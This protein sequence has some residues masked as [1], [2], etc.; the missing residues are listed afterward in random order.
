[1]DAVLE[2]MS[3][4]LLAISW[5]L[6]PMTA[7][8]A[9]QVSRLLA[10]VA[11][12]GWTCDVVTSSNSAFPRAETAE[13]ELAELYEPHYTRNVVT[14][15]PDAAVAA[16][17]DQWMTGGFD[18]AA[19]LLEREQ[20][21]ALV[22][23]A[24]P[25][26]DHLI[27][28]RLKQAHPSLPWVAHFSDPWT[29]SPYLGHISEEARRALVEQ[30]SAIVDAAD[31]VVFVTQETADLVMK[32]YETRLRRKVRV[33]PHCLDLDSMPMPRADQQ[34]RV[35]ANVLSLVHAGSLYEGLRPAGALLDAMANVRRRFRDM[36]V[37]LHFLGHNPDD[38]TAEILGRGLQ[39][40]VTVSPPCSWSESLKIASAADVLLVIDRP[41]K[42][43][44][45]L[46]SK[47][48]EY[49]SLDRRIL[50]LT[51][52]KG[53][54]A[55]VMADLGYRT[56]PPDRASKIAEA[57]RELVVMRRKG[58]PLLST[59]HVQVRD[60][61]SAYKVAMAFVGV[62]G[63]AARSASVGRHTSPLDGAEIV[64]D[65]GGAGT[66]A[67]RPSVADAYREF[68]VSLD[69]VGDA[70]EK[71]MLAF[72][73]HTRASQLAHILKHPRVA[74][75]LLSWDEQEI[76]ALYPGRV[77]Q[78][79]FGEALWHLPAV[80]APTLMVFGY[81]ELIGARRLIDCL[82]HGIRKIAIYSPQ[83]LRWQALPI[84]LLL[85]RVAINRLR[86]SGGFRQHQYKSGPALEARI[87]GKIR[88]ALKQIDVNVTAQAPPVQGRI[89]MISASLDAGG[90]ERQVVNTAGSLIRQGYRDVSILCR[91]LGS[92]NPSFFRGAA[93]EQGA[94][95]TEISTFVRA[96]LDRIISSHRERLRR[97]IQ[98]LP[99]E[100]AG[101]VVPL[102]AEL[103]L[104]RPQVMHAW[105]DQVNVIAG[106]AAAIAGVPRII[107]AGRSVAP[108]NFVFY[109]PHMWGAYRALAEFPN[110]VITNNSR[111]GARDYAQWL[112]LPEDRFRVIRNGYDFAE[113]RGRSR[114]EAAAFRQRHGFSS[115][116][117]VIGTIMRFSEEKQPFLW[118]EA[119]AR[120]SREWPGVRFLMIGDGPMHE[121]AGRLAQALGM[122]ARISMPGREKDAMLALSSMDLFLLTSRKE[123]LPNTLIE[124]QAAGVPVVST[125]A[126]GA[127]EAFAQGVTGFLVKE[128]TAE[129]LARQVSEIL[130]DGA[131]RQR[132]AEAAPTFVR[133][134][135]S[136][137]RLVRETLSIYGLP[138]TRDVQAGRA[139]ARAE[140]S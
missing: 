2:R 23:F 34:G 58:T 54:T 10:H 135:F 137:D 102:V 123:G 32:K 38:L 133:E 22:T 12:Q 67:R 109:Q 21:D 76:T 65:V 17:S 62:L 127:G 121:E 3:K 98:N 15:T 59:H 39:D 72:F 45:F 74:S 88:R 60:R 27:G 80:K 36:T 84:A 111:A 41:A 57:L 108:Y 116:A 90:A 71:F 70:S 138:E 25:W 103:L 64:G 117:T 52:S 33:V 126:G 48:I 132:A 91:N 124:A 29:D 122:G 106:I 95:V 107:L 119:M 26:S 5:A 42:V 118:I 6:L 86:L 130:A 43:N 19:G 78:F 66:E 30:E 73:Q 49:L 14:T 55:G 56:A 46:P 28:L 47:I 68:E 93:E 13:R 99:S 114:R 85:A 40:A 16:D 94:T 115:D 50:A 96:D 83:A 110:V 125:D 92:H 87:A 82:K 37:R 69:T 8:R 18:T 100:L 9:I 63:E 104:R 120:V 131:W 11:R 89:V 134:T 77:G 81:T 139:M 1:M 101:E 35:E 75:V 53:A 61:Y 24:Q 4:R 44:V 140:G 20:F 31:A 105:Q 128:P 129:A 112:K 7:P 136:R 113:V 97:V 51:P 79:R